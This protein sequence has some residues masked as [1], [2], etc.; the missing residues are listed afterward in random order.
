M[1]TLTRTLSLAACAAALALAAPAAAQDSTAVTPARLQAAAELLASQHMDT[2]Y[3]KI[4]ET[5][6]QMEAGSG[7]QAEQF[8]SL[9]RDF[10]HRYLT[11]DA[12]R[13][14]YARIYAERFTE[15]EMRQMAAFYRTPAGQH[16]VDAEPDLTR[17]AGEISRRRVTEHAAELEAMFREHM[18][19]ASRSAAGAAGAQ[20]KKPVAP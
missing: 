19:S 3:E 9:L 18:P 15:D 4:L 10:F 5:T 11:W 1:R 20:G 14:D 8:R 16:L 7:P 17:E 12:I 13:D 2:N 6:V